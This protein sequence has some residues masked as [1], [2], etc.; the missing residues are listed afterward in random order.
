MRCNKCAPDNRQYLTASPS[1]GSAAIVLCEE[2]IFSVRLQVALSYLSE[3][4]GD[5]HI[6]LGTHLGPSSLQREHTLLV[7]IIVRLIPVPRDTTK[8]EAC[9]TLYNQV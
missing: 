7:R 3:Q 1:H 2:F 9:P 6:D 8:D 5:L 4:A